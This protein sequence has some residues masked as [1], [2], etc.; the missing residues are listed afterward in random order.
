LVAIVDGGP[1][2]IS[3]IV[4]GVLCDGGQRWQYGWARFSPQLYNLNTAGQVR[5]APAG[6]IQIKNLRVYNRYLRTSEAVAHF[7][8]GPR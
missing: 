6:T 8:A 5:I 2:I 4:D 7:T 3:W 1:K